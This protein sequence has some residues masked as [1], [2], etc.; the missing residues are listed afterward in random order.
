MLMG[1][2]RKYRTYRGI[3]IAHDLC[4]M[5]FKEV[6]IVDGTG[7]SNGRGGTLGAGNWHKCKRINP[8]RNSDR[9]GL[10]GFAIVEANPE[11]FA[12]PLRLLPAIMNNTMTIQVGSKLENLPGMTFGPQ[13]GYNGEV[14]FLVY[15]ENEKNPFG[16]KGAFFCR[17]E[18]GIKPMKNYLNTVCYLYRSCQQNVLTRCAT[19]GTSQSAVALAAAVDT[20]DS[21]AN[22]DIDLTNSTVIVRL[23]SAIKATNG[24]TVTV[25][26]ASETEPGYIVDAT[27]APTYVIGFPVTAFNGV[28]GLSGAQT[29]QAAVAAKFTTATTVQVA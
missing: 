10:N 23:A 6:G 2:F 26:Q 1:S 13:P 11:Y 16:E 7:V 5:R 15:P 18:L 3:T 24:T 9:I 25:A 19:D 14:K 27:L 29:S 12:A 21:S 22:T 8:E 20:T 28:L 17:Y 4:Q